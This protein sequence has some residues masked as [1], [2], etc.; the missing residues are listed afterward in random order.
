MSQASGSRHSI[1]FIKESTYGVTPDT[2]VFKAFRHKTTSINLAK[3]IMQSEENRGDR[4]IADF[5]HGTRSVSGNIVS[6]L[7]FGSFDDILENALGGVWA[8]NVLKAGILRSSFSI[9]RRF[10]DVGQFL[11]YTGV[12]VDS[13]AMP[14]TTGSLIEMTFGFLGQNMST[15]TSIILGATY[16]A[17]STTAPMSALGGTVLE[18][19]SPI[20]V[21]TDFSWNLANGL[22]SRFVIG[23]D[24]S[25][26]PNIA[27]S[28]VTGTLVAFFETAG[29]YQ[30]FISE[31][32]SSIQVSASDGTSSY[33]ILFPKIKFTGGDVP[34]SGEGSVSVTMPFQAL[35]DPV[36]GTNIQI[37]RNL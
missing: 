31:T 7:S 14:M 23:T 3:A 30:K 21:V 12:Q 8:S 11:R 20:G 24:I 29:L 34:M 32:T 33:D 19:G 17:A 10:N 15:D 1:G 36:T 13:L 2:P 18:G 6:E 16:P 22:S 5:R 35:L 9:E 25:L 28:N 27:R 4:Q 26:E 37:T